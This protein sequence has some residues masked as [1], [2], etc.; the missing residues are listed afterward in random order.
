M[1]SI[2]VPD[3]NDSIS[4]ISLSGKV[5]F[6]R[7]TYNPTFQYWSMGVHD[8]DLNPVVSMVKVVPMY[9]LIEAYKTYTTMPDG[10]IG[11]Y[12]NLKKVTRDSFKNG[13]AVIAYIPHSELGDDWNPYEKGESEESEKITYD[14]SAYIEELLSDE[15]NG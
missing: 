12:T 2:S 8:E 1:I 10:I 5:Y 6:L 15:V 9:P 13:E 7:F 14:L 11:C 3:K 4:K